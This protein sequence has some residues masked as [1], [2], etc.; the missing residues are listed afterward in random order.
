MKVSSNTGNEGSHF[1]RHQYFGTANHD[2]T[3]TLEKKKMVLVFEKHLR[4]TS[5]SIPTAL[6]K[7]KNNLSLAQ[8]IMHS[9]LCKTSPKPQCE[10]HHLHDNET[11]LSPILPIKCI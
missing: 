6:K 11:P 7:K 2:Y 1:I 8:T 3:V 10:P 4:S 9:S 5:G